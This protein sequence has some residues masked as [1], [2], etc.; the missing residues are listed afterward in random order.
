MYCFASYHWGP[1]I[2]LSLTTGPYRVFKSY[3]KCSIEEVE[4]D[5]IKTP[6][7]IEEV[8]YD[9]IKTTTK[10]PQANIS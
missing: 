2:L 1:L 9:D 3:L 7:S 4:Y 10:I 5:D 8:E 6:C